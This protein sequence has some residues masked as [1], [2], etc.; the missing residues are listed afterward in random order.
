MVIQEPIKNK[1][2]GWMKKKGMRM[3]GCPPPNNAFIL[4]LIPPPSSPSQCS[5]R[6]RVLEGFAAL[7]LGNKLASVQFNSDYL[8]PISPSTSFPTSS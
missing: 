6:F 2:V 3:G 1:E 4:I 7:G 8:S 5:H